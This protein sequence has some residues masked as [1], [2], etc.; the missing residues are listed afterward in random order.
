MRCPP[1]GDILVSSGA[2]EPPEVLHGPQAAQCTDG[3]IADPRL[4]VLDTG[5][6]RLGHRPQRLGV[7]IS[8]TKRRQGPSG[9]AF[10]VEVLSRYRLQPRPLPYAAPEGLG[11]RQRGLV[12]AAAAQR[13]GDR[14]AEAVAVAAQSEEHPG[15]GLQELRDGDAGPGTPLPVAW[16][17]RRNEIQARDCQ[18]DVPAMEH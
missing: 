18:R 8:V 16:Q 1:R 10:V 3:A 6:N 15:D 11:E 7:E 14:D 5:G 17:P 2:T 12:R 4:L 13:V 9:A